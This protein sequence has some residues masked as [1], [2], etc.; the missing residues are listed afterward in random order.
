[1]FEMDI[2]QYW[3]MSVKTVALEDMMN[4]PHGFVKSSSMGSINGYVPRL[5]DRSLGRFDM[6]R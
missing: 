6:A 5:T 4:I 3:T 2:G 1:M